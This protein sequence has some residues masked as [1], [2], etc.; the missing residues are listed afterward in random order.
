M[1]ILHKYCISLMLRNWFNKHNTSVYS[2]QKNDTP[3]ETAQP[4]G[5]GLRTRYKKEEQ[6][7]LAWGCKKIVKRRDYY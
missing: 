4:H 7:W 1:D 6:H 3:A 5:S 2:N